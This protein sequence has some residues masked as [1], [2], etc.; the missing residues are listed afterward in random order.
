MP[1]QARIA[2]YRFGRW[3]IDVGRRE[4]RTGGVRVPLGSRAFDIIEVLVQEPGTLVAKEEL[5]RRL[6]PEAVVDDNTLQVHISAIRRALGEDRGLIKTTSGRGYRLLGAWTAEY[7][8]PSIAAGDI[9][10]APPTS[11]RSAGNLPLAATALI[12]REEAKRQV[13]ARLSAHRVVTLVG[14]GG[15]GKTRLGVEVAGDLRL[16][17]P[18]GT[19]FV[20]LSPLS[21]AGLVPSVTAGAI[22][23]DLQ[24]TDITPARAARAI[25]EKQLLIVLDNCEHVID[26][27]AEIAEAIAHTCARATILAT[28]REP[29]RIEAEGVYRVPPLD[30]PAD[31]R[32]SPAELLQHSSVQLFVARLQ[33]LHP[34][35][36]EESARMV[37]IAA[38]CRR[39]DGIPFAIELAAASA[40]T[41]GLEETIRQLNRRFQLLTGGRRTAPPRQRTLLAMF[42]WSYELLSE[43]ERPI[44]RQLGAFAGGF[45]LDAACA[46]AAAPG[47]D[48]PTIIDGVT[49]LATKSLIVVE[50]TGSATRYFLLETMRAY[51]I[52]RL[53]ASG[54]TEAVMRRHA[55]FY[56][57]WLEQA[58]AEWAYRPIGEWLAIHRR[59]IDNVRAALDWA[60]SAH[61]DPVIAIMLSTNSIPLM[62]DLS[63][64]TE[65]QRRA[66]DALRLVRNG[67]QPDPRCEM[68]LLT[69]L[70][71]TRIYTEGPSAAAFEAWET[72]LRLATEHE[73]TE[74]QARALWGLWH[75]HIYS[76]SPGSALVFARRFARL[77]GELGDVAKV[78]L[79]QRLI[80]TSLHY[81]GDQVAARDHLEQF[82]VRYVHS[83]HR[84]RTVSARL[85]HA[86]VARAT[87]TRV[88]WLR[89][90]ADAAVRLS[91][92]AVAD[93][94]AEDHLISTL[95]VLVEAAIPLALAIG[96]F[97]STERFLAILQEQAGR[98]GFRIW[99]IYANC[100]PEV[101]RVRR[102]NQGSALTRLAEAIVELR[103][104]GFCAHLSMFLGAL[105][106]GY[107]D[108]GRV[109][110]GLMTVD[111]AIDRTN[112]HDE[113]WN[114]PEMLRIRA[115][116]LLRQQSA[117]ADITAEALLTRAMTWARSQGALS[118][119]LR[120]ATNLAQLLRRQGHADR[121]LAVL[122]PVYGQF[123]EGFGTSDLRT[124]RALLGNP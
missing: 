53:A 123:R 46:V 91:D 48:I 95:Y 55:Q 4:V 6:W 39:L 102:G 5:G 20:D 26:A 114:G 75:D 63:L 86:T 54:E 24:G 35:P 72:V 34:R 99:Q 56:Q 41:L 21:N 79:G 60:F 27:A 112:R 47:M 42:D 96:D 118:W 33:A 17:F 10:P 93:A 9:D 44:L 65:C 85:D 103:E 22:G 82:L 66:E 71:A 106:R 119:E 28:S 70:Q 80:G 52:D 2:I 89:G 19:W 122:A 78:T 81:H 69:A 13:A 31:D 83:E 120:A 29:L 107:L 38:I 57:R 115:I 68:Q 15:I 116:L 64:I 62:L 98:S 58:G 7:G 124:A 50:R 51:A 14:P 100:L 67:L 45:T 37:A 32:A 87:L 110:D 109:E 97:A 77:A 113:G 105:A 117:E 30:V 25:G 76:G 36:E 11:R 94:F 59:E 101:L 108:A 88:L 3:E 16:A 23:L 61:G 40:A 8:T 73:D 90:E 111:E 12:G 104:T 43:N 1:G 121:A 84:W 74:Y 92:A 18:D 49:G